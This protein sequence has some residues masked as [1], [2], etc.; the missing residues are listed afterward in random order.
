MCLAVAWDGPY[1]ALDR[2]TD[3]WVNN[4]GTPL[5]HFTTGYTR[6]DGLRTTQNSG[7]TIPRLARWGI[8]ARMP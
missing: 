5:V 3:E 7:D 4:P 1:D 8:L 6:L 2:L